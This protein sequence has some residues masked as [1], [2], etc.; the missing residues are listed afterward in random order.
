MEVVQNQI[1]PTMQGP[2]LSESVYDVTPSKE[3]PSPTNEPVNVEV[4][5][6]SPNCSPLTLPEPK[7]VQHLII[8]EPE[9]ILL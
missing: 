5:P 7:S 9:I 6:T 3:V 8:V 1:T 4:P 2:V